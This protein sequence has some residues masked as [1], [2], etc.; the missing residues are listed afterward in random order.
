MKL[1]SRSSSDSGA[2]PRAAGLNQCT[3]VP[4]AI[5][6]PIQNNRPAAS[7][8]LP[9]GAITVATWDALSV[10]DLKSESVEAKLL[11]RELVRCA[12]DRN[13]A[14]IGK[15]GRLLRPLFF[16]ITAGFG[17]VCEWYSQ[18]DLVDDLLTFL[19][20]GLRPSLIEA[21]AEE[22]DKT[23]GYTFV[24]PLETWLAH[25]DQPLWSFVAASARNVCRDLHRRAKARAKLGETMASDDARSLVIDDNLT[26]APAM[27]PELEV[28][29]SERARMF[30]T[31]F[32]A[33]APRELNVLAAIQSGTPQK[34][35]AEE[36]A[37]SEA[38]I[39]RIKDRAITKMRAAMNVIDFKDN[40]Q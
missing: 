35:I 14:A 15:L 36:L 37:L 8:L 25:A 18:P 4:Q 39:S 9:N 17:R 6:L 33:L 3:E 16:A 40:E 27:T 32:A 23:S 20:G 30:D 7:T 19:V 22:T 1:P 24:P 21:P 26:D 31:A 28:L 13:S 12:L 29:E 11:V 38:L 34:L 10:A 5:I 2:V